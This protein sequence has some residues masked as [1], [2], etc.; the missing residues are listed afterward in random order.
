MEQQKRHQLTRGETNCSVIVRCDK[1]IERWIDEILK[2]SSSNNP[3]R[4]KRRLFPQKRKGIW[5]SICHDAKGKDQLPK[6]GQLLVQQEEHQDGDKEGRIHKAP[7]RSESG[8]VSSV[9]MDASEGTYI[10]WQGCMQRCQQIEGTL[11]D[12]DGG[13]PVEGGNCGKVKFYLHLI[14][15][16]PC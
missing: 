3:G 11:E 6:K 16:G 4:P 1:I 14:D 8:N 13:V 15:I 5:V 7:V 12:Q 10:V 9:L 2:I